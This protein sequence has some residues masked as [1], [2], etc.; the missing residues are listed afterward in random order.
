MIYQNQK[1]RKVREYKKKL[2]KKKKNKLK[3]NY[4]CKEFKNKN[5]IEM[6]EELKDQT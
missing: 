6:K 1:I 3:K 4:I 5:K 2:I